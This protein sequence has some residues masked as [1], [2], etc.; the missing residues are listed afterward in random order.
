MISIFQEGEEGEKGRLGCCYSTEGQR[1]RCERQQLAYLDFQT[2]SSV[3][4]TRTGAALAQLS[5]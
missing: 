1:G 3:Q 4:S 5:F 2:S